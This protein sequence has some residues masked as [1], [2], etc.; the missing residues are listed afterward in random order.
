MISR[1]LGVVMCCVFTT[2]AAA[3]SYSD[4]NAGIA[5]FKRRDFDGASAHM[6]AALA[7]PDLNP[8]FRAPAY[9]IRGEASMLAKQPT[10]AIADLSAALAA[11]P[12]YSDAYEA[13]AACYVATGQF[14]LA[15]ADITALIRS[16][17]FST[18]PYDQ[19]A[20]IYLAQKNFDAALADLSTVVNLAPKMAS[21][22]II[23][24]AAYREHGDYVKALA[25]LDKAD[26]ISSGNA[27]VYFERGLVHEAM[28]DYVRARDDYGEA[29]RRLPASAVLKVH[30]AL[31][32]WKTGDFAGAVTAFQ[33]I[34][35]S[36]DKQ[37]APYAALWTAL[38]AAAGGDADMA[39]AITSNLDRSKWPG[40]MLDLYAGTSTVDAMTKAASTGDANMQPT[41]ICEAEFYGGMWNVLHHN[42]GAGKVQLETA[43]ANCAPQDIEHDAAAVALRRLP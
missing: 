7:A 15:I 24:S 17:P 23:R 34:R 1:I 16:K 2:G 19:R 31:L 12:L 29:S 33:A 41:Q 37:T 9:A 36:G 11:D 3:S 40:P 20:A 6:T 21:S 5:A 18:V 27:A 35:D 42:S 14:D 8:A 26:D 39:K 30:L 32:S 22:Y 10:K 25:D 38:S 4:F 28:A 13:R 43:A